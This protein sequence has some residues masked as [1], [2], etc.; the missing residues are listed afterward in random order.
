M[1][2]PPETGYGHRV[3]Q[4]FQR[5][6]RAFVDC[7]CIT[8]PENNTNANFRQWIEA[9]LEDVGREFLSDVETYMGLDAA[10]GED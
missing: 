7:E 9:S 8:D 5:L 6:R 3:R 2:R 4:I 10:I 1:P